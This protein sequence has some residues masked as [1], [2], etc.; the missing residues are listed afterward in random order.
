LE[1]KNLEKLDRI[2]IATWNVNSINQRIEQLKTVLIDEEIDVMMLQEIKCEE[3]NFPRT[4]IESLGYKI[5]LKGQKAYNGVAILSKYPIE[6]V[7]NTIMADD[8]ARYIEGVINYKNQTIRLLNI[9]APHGQSPELP[10]FQYKMLFYDNLTEKVKD[11]LKS[12]EILLVAGDYNIAPDNIDVYDSVKLEG[13]M[14]F[15]IMERRKLRQLLNL[16]L[17]DAFREKYPDC[18]EYTWWDYRSL[19]FQYNRGMKIDH[20]LLS[21]EG[22]DIMQDCYILKNIRALDKPSDHVPVICVLH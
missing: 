11:Y 2:K 14:G 6:E 19:G 7:G 15:H 17:S 12:D 8:D 4:E 13:S 10:R 5:I 20:I 16:G 22:I 9:Y 18:Q 1:E 21:G 3:A